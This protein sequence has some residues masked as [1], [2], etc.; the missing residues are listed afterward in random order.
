MRTET[1][2]VAAIAFA[3]GYCFG[4][5][6]MERRGGMATVITVRDTVTIERPVEVTRKV[7]H[8]VVE[9]LRDTVGDTVTVL[10]PMERV[11]Y[12]GPGYEARVS[13]YRPSLDSISIVNTT[14]SRAP[15]RWSVGVQAGVGMTPR[16]MQP[17]VGVG[18]SVR[19]I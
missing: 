17:Y 10:V 19:I 14:V 5:P 15:R 1:F 6:C 13:G 8:T 9:T 18:V 4:S 16:G 11:V 12:R 2:V 7:T 3:A